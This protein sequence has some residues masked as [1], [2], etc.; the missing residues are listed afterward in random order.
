MKLING[1][2]FWVLGTAV[3]LTGCKTI[4]ATSET[5]QSEIPSG[6]T[7]LIT[8]TMIQVKDGAALLDKMF[9]EKKWLVDSGDNYNRFAIKYIPPFSSL[10]HFV[11]MF[12][13]ECES[14]GGSYRNS[15]CW[16]EARTEINFIAEGFVTKYR[17]T[18][19]EIFLNVIEPRNTTDMVQFVD[20]IVSKVNDMPSIKFKSRG[21]SRFEKLQ[22]L[23]E[24][25]DDISDQIVTLPGLNG[26]TD[27]ESLLAS[28]TLHDALSNNSKKVAI[29][30]YGGDTF[31]RVEVIKKYQEGTELCADVSIYRNEGVKPSLGEM[32][33]G[34]EGKSRNK[35]TV[36][37][38]SDD[39]AGLNW[40]FAS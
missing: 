15:I 24:L 39:R 8:R 25:Y 18:Y 37:T 23:E 5:L 7:E 9:I 30:N 40:Y 33:S 1:L 14:L 6:P 32:L 4:S 22:K 36:C 16:K 10:D 21:L 11:S 13:A 12:S 19:N 26:I 35:N 17:D 3:L 31:G 20:S 28:K 27:Y 2:L 38:D 34:N 29:W